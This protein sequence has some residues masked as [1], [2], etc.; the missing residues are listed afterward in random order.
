MKNIIELIIFIAFIAAIFLYPTLIT[1]ISITAIFLVMIAV[2]KWRS[3]KGA[4]KP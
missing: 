1:G 2:Q 4:P 3:K